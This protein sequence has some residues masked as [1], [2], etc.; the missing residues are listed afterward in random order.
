[1]AGEVSFTC[2]LSKDVVPALNQPQL[3]YALLEIAPMGVMANVRM[4]LNFGLVLDRSGSMAGD[5]IKRLRDAVSQIVDRLEPGDYISVVA[6]DRSTKVLVPSQT[7]QDREGIKR[8]ATRLNAGSTTEIASAL[9]AGLAEVRKQWALQ[10]TNR[11]VLLT[12]GHPT[13]EAAD[14]I[15][16]A[17]AAS[18]EGVPIIALGLGDDWNETFLQEIAGR[19]GPQGT[20]HYIATPQDTDRIFDDVWQ[21]MQIVARDVTLTLRLVQGVN[22]R[23]VWQVTPF[24]KDLG[25]SPLSDRFISVPLGDLEQQG[26]AVLAELSL[27]PHAP[28]RYRMAQAE[29]SYSVPARNLTGE[30][31]RTDLVVT[32][33][34]DYYAAQAVNPKVMS[35]VE[36]VTAF[37]L[38]TRALEEAQMGNAIGATQKLRS[39]VTILLGQEDAASLDLAH[40]L[41]SE[42]DR[43]QQGGQLSEEGKRTIKFESRKTVK[44][45]DL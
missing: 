42:L 38:Q 37:N 41:Q 15:Q 25:Y 34:P 2:T 29:A 6:F 23:K 22:P 31:V 18:S 44:L 9:R 17:E 24:I 5:K 26:M 3:A 33:S 20:V 30:T 36:R 27:M 40:T 4:P 10:R 14:S 21:Q 39:A 11:L 35:V 28:G 43:L 19:S 45:S 7:A 13:D 32:M 1:M 8:Q 16:M 12:D